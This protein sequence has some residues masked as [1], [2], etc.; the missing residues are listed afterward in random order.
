M[1]KLYT[2]TCISRVYRSP[3]ILFRSEFYLFSVLLSM[4]LRDNGELQTISRFSL[5]LI[6]PRLCLSED[7]SYP[8]PFS[9]LSIYLSL[10]GNSFCKRTSK[11]RSHRLHSVRIFPDLQRGSEYF[12]KENRI[13]GNEIF[14][15]HFINSSEYNVFDFKIAISVLTLNYQSIKLTQFFFY[16][17]RRGL[18][19]C[20]EL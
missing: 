20:T 14:L 10:Q 2:Y 19:M 6:F 17:M 16:W 11:K 3:I 4:N 1:R 8:L 9:H 15:H 7:D 13:I 5:R 12:F 18:G